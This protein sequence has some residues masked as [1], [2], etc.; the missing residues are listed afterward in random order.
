MDRNK[1][2]IAVVVIVLLLLGGLFF[3]SNKNGKNQ[4]SQT[5]QNSDVL[6]TV[7]SSVKVDI[8]GVESNHKIEM[9][10][11]GVPKGTQSIDYE[12]TYE[13]VD[14]GLPGISSTVEVQDGADKVVVPADKLELGTCSSGT[15][16]HPKITGKIHVNL[17]FNGTYGS[18]IYSNDFNL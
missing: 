12:I 18:K 9:T 6:P 4:S 16:V 2:I 1:I 15:C 3:L 14:G 17:K 8:K 10:I 5:Q 7:D 11:A 13:T